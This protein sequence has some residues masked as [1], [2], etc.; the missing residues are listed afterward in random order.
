MKLIV[1]GPRDYFDAQKL[2]TALD[3][4]V[5]EHG[6]PEIVIQGGAKGVDSLAHAWAIRSGLPVHTVKALWDQHGRG[7]GPI[8][9]AQMAD[10]GDT[11]VAVDH[12]TRGTQN[13]IQT[14]RSKNLAVFTIDLR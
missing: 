11:L 1:A 4:F 3:E 10:L 12:G 9:N 6:R 5:E 13:M 2:Y 8:R 7:A 14:A